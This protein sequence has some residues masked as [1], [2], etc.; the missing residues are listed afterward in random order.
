MAVVQHTITNAAWTAISTAGQSGTCWL[1]ENDQSNDGA[2]DVRIFHG[3]TMPTYNDI[4]YGARV[5]L[6][7]TNQDILN[8][9]ADNA[10]DIFWARAGGEKP[11]ILIADMR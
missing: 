9:T 1:N 6:P 7:R 4:Q 2:D 11:A 3:P 5:R 8:L 10:L